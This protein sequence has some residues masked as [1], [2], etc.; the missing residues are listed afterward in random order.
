MLESVDVLIGLIVVLLALSMTVTVIT[1]ALTAIV[2]SR[3]LHLRRGLVDLLQLLD[4]AFDKTKARAVASQILRHSLVSGSSVFGGLLKPRLGNVVHRE[5]FIKLLIGLALDQR[6]D[7]A[8][9]DAEGKGQ[10]A[11]PR[12]QADRKAREAVKAALKAHDV[13]PAATLQ[14]IRSV[15]LQFERTA[16]ELSSMARQNAAIL[17]AAPNDFVAKIHNWFDQT[18]DRT[19]QRFT[20]STR[21]ITFAGAFLVAFG[22]QVDTPSLVNRLAADDTMRAAF[23][24]QA[25]AMSPGGAT[26]QPNPSAGPTPPNSERCDNGTQS[27]RAK[28]ARVPG[29]SRGQR[30]HQA[31]DER[32]L[33]GRIHARERLRDAHHRVPAQPGRALLVRRAVAAA[34]AA[35]R[36]RGQGRC[37]ARRAPTHH[38]QQRRGG[39]C[40][41]RYGFRGATRPQG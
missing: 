35:L 4:P 10:D 1:Q 5:E 31:A 36:A 16:P 22:L 40:G 26:S 27:Q 14:A 38:R 41:R 11:S 20:A 25:K 15:A 2:N 21:V 12:D 34:A 32:R 6:G 24:E 30:H 37:T 29:V 23:V 8:P 33:G 17:T 28:G 18:M 3:G 39:R 9:K 7:G 13:D 19:S